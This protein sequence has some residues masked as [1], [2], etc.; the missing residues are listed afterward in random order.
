MFSLLLKATRSGNRLHFHNFTQCY[1]AIVVRALILC[2]CAYRWGLLH[3]YRVGNQQFLVWNTADALLLLF[4]WIWIA[5][6]RVYYELIVVDVKNWLRA[7]SV[8][9]L[10]PCCVICLACARVHLLLRLMLLHNPY[11]L[12]LVDWE[13]LFGVVVHLKNGCIHRTDPTLNRVYML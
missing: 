10:G 13:L 5:R 6:S 12:R 8:D 4:D 11:D 3:N 7:R 9:D 2:I 1:V